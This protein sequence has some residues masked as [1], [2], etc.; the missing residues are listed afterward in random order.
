MKSAEKTSEDVHADA[1]P[2]ASDG[3]P[4]VRIEMAAS[5]LIRTG[6]FA[7][8]TVGP[9]KVTMFIDPR[10][11][12]PITSEIKENIVAAMNLLAEIVEVEVVGVQREL[13][14]EALSA[15]NKSE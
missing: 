10:E 9:A 1:H 8:V 14:L 11:E 2:R 3:H 15:D 4:L 13:V 12:E 6:E 7:N 5:E